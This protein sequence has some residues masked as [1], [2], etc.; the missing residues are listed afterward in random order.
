LSS[1]KI[2]RLSEIIFSGSS[3]FFIALKLSR[4]NIGVSVSA[5]FH[6]KSHENSRFT[7]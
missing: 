4:G 5:K 6:G 1:R 3:E 7:P 2:D